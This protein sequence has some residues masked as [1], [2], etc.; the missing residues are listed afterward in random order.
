MPWEGATLY[1]A[2]FKLEDE[3][4]LTRSVE[5]AGKHNTVSVTQPL[6]GL[7]ESKDKLFFASDET[8]YQNIWVVDTAQEGAEARLAMKQLD[9]DFTTPMW[10]LGTCDY[11]LLDGKTGLVAP[12][13]DRPTL[14]HF[15][16][17][18]GKI[19]AIAGGE[20]YGKIDQLKRLSDTQAVFIGSKSDAPATLVI[21]TLGSSAGQ[22]DFSEVQTT[23]PEHL[24]KPV[25]P[26]YA[27]RPE[28]Y[29]LRVPWNENAKRPEGMSEDTKE[30]DLHVILFPPT[31]PKFKAPEGTR[32]PC[33]VGVHGGP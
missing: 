32:P 27:S 25:D 5:V 21:V 9:K 29:T 1:Y 7:G 22:A 20:V 33:L 2:S 6:W 16:L 11:A 30:V 8:G 12:L 19:V 17:R 24:K 23:K 15:D 13:N 31:N 10:S 18:S 26:A 4:K 14:S 3:P 28:T